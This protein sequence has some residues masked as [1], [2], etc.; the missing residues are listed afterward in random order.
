M[1]FSTGFFFFNVNTAFVHSIIWQLHNMI[2]DQRIV[3]G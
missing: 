1:N 2:I 3:F